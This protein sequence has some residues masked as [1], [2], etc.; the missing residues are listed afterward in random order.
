[1]I[2]KGRKAP[3]FNLESDSGEWISLKDLK[4]ERFV[5]YFYP[6]DDTSGCTLEACEFRDNL[7]K[8]KR[9]GVK[10]FGVSPDTVRKHVK[11]KEKHDL[12]FTLLS[13]PAHEVCEKYGVWGEKMFWGR[14]YM[15][16]LRTTFVIGE[17]GYVEHV[18]EDVK[19]EGHAAEVIAWLRAN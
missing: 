5:L 7:P 9:A 2:R 16:V 13:D 19:P 6:K 1:M 11:F 18:W 8:F 10:V 4:G 3:A 17:N 15:G 14:K 12:P